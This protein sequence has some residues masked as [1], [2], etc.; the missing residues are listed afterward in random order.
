[1]CHDPQES[2][3]GQAVD[4]KTRRLEAIKTDMVHGEQARCKND[5]PPITVH[6][7]DRQHDENPEVQ[8]QHAARQLNVQRHERH[9]QE[10]EQKTACRGATG[11]C[12]D[13]DRQQQQDD[14]HADRQT[15]VHELQ[16]QEDADRGAD[17]DGGQQHA[18][19]ESVEIQYGGVGGVGL[20]G[21]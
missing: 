5:H 11:H 3:L 21:V 7:Q 1:M 9:Q 17:A 12:M 2:G 15:G 18:V 20:H 10:A 8:L 4:A 16:A 13:C 14:A 6:Q 19:S